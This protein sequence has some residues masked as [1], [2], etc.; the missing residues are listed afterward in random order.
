M[1]TIAKVLIPNKSWLIEEEGVK[2]GTLN[3]EKKGFSL[4][5]QGERFEFGS[6]KTVKEQLGITYIDTSTNVTKNIKQSEHSV[7]DFP[8]SRKTRMNAINTLPIENLLSKI[9]IANK[10]G[11]KTVVLDIKDAV[12]VAD[13]LT[14]VMTRLTGKLDE[15]LRNRAKEPEVIQIEMDGGGFSGT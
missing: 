7:Y 12:A 4:L 10:S 13:S 1:N 5:R 8:C 11:Q 14:I 15:Q 3:K 6:I 9:R 2:L